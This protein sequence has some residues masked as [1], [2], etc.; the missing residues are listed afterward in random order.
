MADCSCD[1]IPE[2]RLLAHHHEV[3]SC[4]DCRAMWLAGHKSALAIQAE[5]H[6]IEWAV[7]SDD[8]TAYEVEGKTKEKAEYEASL[9]RQPDGDGYA[10]PGAHVVMRKVCGWAARST[11]TEALDPESTKENP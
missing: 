3:E 4:D 11:P 1:F 2:A 6:R 7:M 8:G 5:A 9:L 10:E